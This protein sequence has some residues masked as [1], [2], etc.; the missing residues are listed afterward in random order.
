ML[1]NN[2]YD[3]LNGLVGIRQGCLDM[4]ILTETSSILLSPAYVKVFIFEL[5]SMS[6]LTSKNTVVNCSI[7]GQID[8]FW[9][10]RKTIDDTVCIINLTLI[11]KGHIYSLMSVSV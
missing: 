10:Q 6:K 11:Y 1:K 8:F 5:K 2:K 3:W 9:S 7:V 4:F